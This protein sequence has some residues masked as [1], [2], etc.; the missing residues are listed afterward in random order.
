MFIDIESIAVQVSRLPLDQQCQV[1]T[2]FLDQMMQYLR[3]SLETV[4]RNAH[5]VPSDKQAH[6]ARLIQEGIETLAKMEQQKVEFLQRFEQFI[7]EQGQN[8][9]A[10]QFEQ[11]RH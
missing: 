2:N 4:Q 6:Q 9:L 10:Q 3:S 1:M 11:L 8:E 5:L 7:Q